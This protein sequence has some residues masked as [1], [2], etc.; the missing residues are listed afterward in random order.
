MRITSIIATIL[1]AVTALGSVSASAAQKASTAQ[2]VGTWE[3]VSAPLPPGETPPAVPLA[4]PAAAAAPLGSV[5]VAEAAA[6]GSIVPGSDHV[7]Q[8]DGHGGVILPAS[9]PILSDAVELATRP[10]E[11]LYVSVYLPRTLG[12]RAPRSLF[13]YVAGQRGT[14][15]A[16]IPCRRCS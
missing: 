12:L 2:W 15:A 6:D 5:H 14:S 10:L 7:V 9:A 4:T 8:F 3:Y 13:E 16:R 11:K 1:S